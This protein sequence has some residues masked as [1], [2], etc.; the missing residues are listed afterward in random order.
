MSQVTVTECHMTR[1]TWGPW[2]SK[3]IATVVKC[4]SSRELSKNSIEFS[5]SN[6]DKG[7]VGL[8]LALELASLTL[9][10]DSILWA[11]SISDPAQS[12]LSS[13]STLSRWSSWLL[14]TSIHSR[15]LGLRGLYS[16]L[17]TAGG[18]TVPSSGIAFKTWPCNW[19]VLSRI[20]VSLF[21]I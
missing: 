15:A 13:L 8:I 16:Q 17:G 1:V 10:L 7:A 21:S 4:I 9:E 19:V 11:L 12:L 20:L 2:E 6:T 14:A 18:D 3:C 5:L